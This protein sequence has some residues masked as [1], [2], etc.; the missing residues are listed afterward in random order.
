MLLF[1]SSLI[2][3][4][5]TIVYIILLYIF[6]TVNAKPRTVYI[7]SHIPHIPWHALFFSVL[8]LRLRGG[9]HAGQATSNYHLTFCG[10]R[11]LKNRRA[12][13]RPLQPIVM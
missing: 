9:K 4:I 12:V 7:L 8:T 11:P 5:R 13:C 6:F 3:G 10:A 1:L 2:G